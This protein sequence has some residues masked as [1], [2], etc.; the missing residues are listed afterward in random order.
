MPLD[1]CHELHEI[2]R[3]FAARCGHNFASSPQLSVS[4]FS[5]DSTWSRTI[6]LA[7]I[8]ADNKHAISLHYGIRNDEVERHF[9]SLKSHNPTLATFVVL[10]PAIDS[11]ALQARLSQVSKEL[12]QLLHRIN[13]TEAIIQRI[14][15]QG[16]AT[17]VFGSWTHGS[18]FP[19][20]RT[21]EEIRH[22]IIRT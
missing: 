9:T 13:S 10:N 6:E 19:T 12:D 7:C 16:G 20:G 2:H 1:R 15:E 17:V 14:E 11:E 21:A 4:T 18:S 5:K 22:A 3:V 8:E